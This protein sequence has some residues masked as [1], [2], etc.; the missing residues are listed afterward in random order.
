VRTV[1]APAA[2]THA[3]STATRPTTTVA[4]A[5]T[6][7]HSTAPK[8]TTAA[9][10]TTAPKTTTSA[11]KPKQKLSRV[12]DDFSAPEVDA[13]TWR[14]LTD[15]TGASVA[16]QAGQLAVTIDPGAQAGGPDAAVGGRVATLCTFPDDFDARVDFTL[17]TW[18]PGDNLRAGLSALFADGFVGRRTSVDAGEEYA[19]SVGP[20]IASVRLDETSG[21]LR[22]ARVGGM[23]TTYYWRNGRWVPLASG[24]SSGA[25][26]LS[27][28][29]TA[30]T[31]FGGQEARV[32][33]DDFAVTAPDAF[34]PG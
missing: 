19:A 5:T 18:P 16:E 10:T 11:P 8:P 31:D 15:G 24:R 13:T 14:V 9:R 25:A 26:V 30:G 6:P 33:F 28:G 32:A 29:L 7:V 4:R 17:F 20:H 3:V 23:M 1:T 21:S 22:I 2:G 34:C 27:V 12:A